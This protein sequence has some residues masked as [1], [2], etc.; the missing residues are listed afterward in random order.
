MTINPLTVFVVGFFSATANGSF[1]DFSQ[2]NSAAQQSAQYVSLSSRFLLV[3]MCPDYTHTHLIYLLPRTFSQIIVHISNQCHK[4]QD[5][6]W[7]LVCVC[8]FFASVELMSLPTL[9]NSIAILARHQGITAN[10]LDAVHFAYM[11][12][13]NIIRVFV[14][15]YF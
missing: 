7:L 12:L 9:P 4:N 15:N 2:F 11:C 14:N 5:C 8:F 13:A 3:C 1:G 6:W 10:C